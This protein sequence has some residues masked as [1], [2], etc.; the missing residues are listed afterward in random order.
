VDQFDEIAQSL[1]A[2]PSKAQILLE[3]EDEGSTLDEVLGILEAHV[4]QPIEYEVIRKGNP[5]LVLFYLSTNNMREAVL[6]LTEAG[7]VRLKGVDSI[8]GVKPRNL[9]R[10]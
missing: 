4:D 3:I 7:F 10:N 8:K 6:K 1:H 9:K 5:S 2:H